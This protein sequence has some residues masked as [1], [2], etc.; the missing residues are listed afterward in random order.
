MELK[1]QR[2]EIGKWGVVLGSWG[3][4]IDDPYKYPR[5]AHECPETPRSMLS[6]EKLGMRLH[7]RQTLIDP[8][9][10]SIA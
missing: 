9:M 2:V 7:E 3:I 8:A 1:P 4:D 10:K 5:R 6:T